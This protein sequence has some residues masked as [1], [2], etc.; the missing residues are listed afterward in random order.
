MIYA[1]GKKEAPVKAQAEAEGLD[2]IFRSAG[3]SWGETGCSMCVSMN[4]DTVAE[5]ARCASTSNRNHVGRQGR[6]SRTHLVSPP[7]AALAAIKGHLA[8]IRREGY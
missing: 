2:K 5:G 4:G 8:D 7:M 1:S 6:G 3:A